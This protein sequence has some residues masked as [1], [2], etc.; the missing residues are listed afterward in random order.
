LPG[1]SS[2]T[3]TLTDTKHTNKEQN[4]PFKSINRERGERLKSEKK[5]RTSL[6][7]CNRTNTKPHSE[8]KGGKRRKKRD[9]ISVLKNRR[10]G[11]GEGSAEI[12][13]TCSH[14]KKLKNS[15]G[16]GQCSQRGSPS[17]LELD[18]GGRRSAVPSGLFQK[19]PCAPRPKTVSPAVPGS[20]PRN[21]ITCPATLCEGL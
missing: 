2:T 13:Y 10:E 11:E 18:G 1:E 21:S 9:A 20:P 19:L 17:V 16:N 8:T 3:G 7:K 6:F 14:Q 15:S 12:A 4:L 5:R